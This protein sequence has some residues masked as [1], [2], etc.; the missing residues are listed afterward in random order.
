M[1][2]FSRLAHRGRL[3]GALRWRSGVRLPPG[4]SRKPAL[5]RP[6][7]PL[8]HHYGWAARSSLD[9]TVLAWIAPWKR[10]PGLMAGTSKR[11]DSPPVNAA[12]ER[13]EARRPPGGAPRLASAETILGADRRSIPLGLCSGGQQSQNPDATAPREGERMCT[14]LDNLAGL[15]AEAAKQRR[16]VPLAGIEPARPCGHQILSLARLPVP[17]QGHGRRI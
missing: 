11:G 7:T 4:G 6:R 12:M 3:L 10:G 14:T 15:P 9:G 13:R 8:A 1:I 2:I 5:G 16:L 17:P